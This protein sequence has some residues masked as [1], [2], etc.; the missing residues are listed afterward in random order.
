ME[1]MSILQKKDKAACADKKISFELFSDV[2]KYESDAHRFLD[3]VSSP[4]TDCD[5]SDGNVKSDFLIQ[6][7]YH[8]YI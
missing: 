8:C 1:K 2:L 7:C 5:I 3:D 6:V 4:N